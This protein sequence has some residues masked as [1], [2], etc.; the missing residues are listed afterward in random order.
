MRAWWFVGMAYGIVWAAIVVYWFCLKRR[1]QDA[2]RELTRVQA[3]RTTT[4]NVKT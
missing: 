4:G 3:R 2:Q 1:Y